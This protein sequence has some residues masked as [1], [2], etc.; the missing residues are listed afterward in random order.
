MLLNE[1][2][3][4]VGRCDF[5]FQIKPDSTVSANILATTAMDAPVKVAADDA[6][7]RRNIND[8]DAPC[9]A[10]ISATTT[11]CAFV[12]INNHPPTKTRLG[13]ARLKGVSEGYS[14]CP[15][16]QQQLFDL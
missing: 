14:P 6:I 10:N 11:P 12:R 13:W 1:K 15:Q 2:V 8:S 9:R 7:S 16:R 4:L 3:A 5:V